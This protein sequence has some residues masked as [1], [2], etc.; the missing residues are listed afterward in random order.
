[1]PRGQCEL[2]QGGGVVVG[3]KKA[4]PFLARNAGALEELMSKQYLLSR[5]KSIRLFIHSLR[6]GWLE[7][8]DALASGLPADDAERIHL[9]QLRLSLRRYEQRFPETAGQA[10]RRRAA[11]KVS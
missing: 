3:R 6:E 10:K 9:G 11:A 4:R 1:M 7:E 8:I 5:A 2:L